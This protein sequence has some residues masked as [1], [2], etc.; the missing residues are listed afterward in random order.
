[1]TREHELIKDAADLLWKAY[2]LIAAAEIP[3]DMKEYFL[4]NILEKW[5]DNYI[6]F[7]DR[8][9]KELCDICYPEKKE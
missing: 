2:T 8:Y 6:L 5:C 4:S 9:D 7:C 1:M 3:E